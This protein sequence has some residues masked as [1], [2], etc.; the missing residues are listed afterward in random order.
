M[1]WLGM[2]KLIQDQVF[3]LPGFIPAFIWSLPASLTVGFLLKQGRRL[4]PGWW[5]LL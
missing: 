2:M 5:D 3:N 1:Q 4:I